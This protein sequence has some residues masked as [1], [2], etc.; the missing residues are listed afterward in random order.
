M[1]REM[2]EFTAKEW[3]WDHAFTRN[4]VGRIGA[5]LE[6]LVVRT[7]ASEARVGAAEVAAIMDS[8]MP[9]LG[10]VSFE[11]GGQV[12]L[13]TAPAGSLTACLDATARDVEFLRSAAAHS[14]LSLVGRGLDDRPAARVVDTPRY[15]ELEQSYNRYGPHGRIMMCNSASVQVNVD[16]GDASLGWRGWRRR[17]WLANC[18]GPVFTAMFAN[19]P[20]D[21]GASGYCGRQL[22]RFRTDPTRTDPLP[23]TG[24]PRTRWTDYVLDARVVGVAEPSAD[25]T[26][27]GW[28]R[29]SGPRPVFLSD[30]RRHLKSVI[31]PVRPRGYLELRM[32]DA[33]AG[34]NWVVPM[35]MVSALLDDARASERAA[36]IVE[37]ML[38]PVRKDDWVT[39]AH[40][41]M[42]DPRLAGA[43]LQCMAAAIGAMERLSVPA[44]ARSVM[45]QFADVYTFRARSP[46]AEHNLGGIPCP[47]SGELSSALR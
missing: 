27:R 5:E 26:L 23:L 36:E 10:Y 22:L 3:I 18:L 17:W 30:L 38:W 33:Q 12:E 35:V 14:G 4:R 42:D 2:T 19:S 40:D 28:L 43:A 16:A 41:A 34:D 31:P 44:W 47:T 32:I 37:S 7:D 39:A 13:S 25:L 6:W 9:G 21:S 8:P 46:A 11:A 15:A 24:D 45:H 1:N 20:V 29:G